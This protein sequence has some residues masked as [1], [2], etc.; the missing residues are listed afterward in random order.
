MK[1]LSPSCP[2]PSRLFISS[3]II[4]MLQTVWLMLAPDFLKATIA[5]MEMFPTS[6]SYHDEML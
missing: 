5:K 1:K 6:K 3:G 2:N 4:I